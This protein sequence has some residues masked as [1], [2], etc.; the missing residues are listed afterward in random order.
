MSG[1]GSSPGVEPLSC[2]AVRD[3]DLVDRYLS[4]DLPEPDAESFEAHFFACDACWDRVRA[5]MA[6]R[7]TAE[8]AEAGRREPEDVAG[9]ETIPLT[10]GASSPGDRSAGA[11]G[12][13]LTGGLD[14]RWRNLAAVA[15]AAAVVLGV[16]GLWSGQA[17]QWAGGGAAP[18]D[19]EGPYR[20]AAGELSVDVA[21]SGGGL[22]VAWSP[23]EGAH[24]YLVRFFSA[25]GRLLA[26]ERAEAP[27]LEMNGQDLPDAG[28]AHVSVEARSPGGR[29]LRRS[30]PTPV[31]PVVR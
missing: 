6:L 14:R 1:P 7:E 15:A 11:L 27:G 8:G 24:H 21:R 2:S 30:A 29:A 5:A 19:G 23:V 16:F 26:E 18:S 9:K 22:Q 20:G 31:P 10:T 28:A 13:S 17:V 12:T 4:D 25:D 3:R